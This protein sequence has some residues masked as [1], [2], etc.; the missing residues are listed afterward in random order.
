[1]KDR[2][3]SGRDVEEAV[4]VACRDLGVARE[5]LRY[6]VLDAG[7]A[8]GLGLK[9]TP[10]RIA[11][12]LDAGPARAASPR[13]E[14]AEPE[15]RERGPGEPG[16]DL[17]AVVRKILEAAGLDLSVS[18]ESVEDAVHVRLTG[19]DR[20]FFYG[21]EGEV[22]GAT[23]HLL[24]RM[25]GRR[26]AG[27]RISLECEGYRERRDEAIRALARALAAAVKES[28]EARTTPP[29][30]AYERRLIHLAVGGEEGLV[31]YS[32]GEGE[33]RR[34]TVAPRPADPASGGHER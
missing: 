26:L 32:V 12:L 14:E 22:L 8:P 3:F 9:A 16:E 21:E 17:G 7:T 25:F 10:A 34:V 28:G 11:V 18:L 4:G 23:E 29:L 6:V 15:A 1:M 5:A 19:P 30:N 33:D 2:A 13:R 31:T 20:D 24:Q 27:R